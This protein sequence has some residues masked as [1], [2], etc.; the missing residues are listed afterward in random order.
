MNI[1]I[2][3]D[4]SYENDKLKNILNEYAAINKI[5]LKTDEYNNGESFLKNYSPYAYT[6]VFLDIF[7][8][9]L[10][11]V[12]IAKIIRKSDTDTI[13]VFLTSSVEHMADAFS[14]HAYDYIIKPTCKKKLFRVMDDILHN[15]TTFF[16]DKFSFTT[17]GQS[18][19]LAY[20][21]IVS[22]ITAEHTIV[23][24]PRIEIRPP[25]RGL[26]S[27]GRDRPGVCR[28]AFRIILCGG[29]GAGAGRFRGSFRRRLRR[30][31]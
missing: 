31:Q 17:E 18:Y 19:A 7:M 27:G 12:D 13:I 20:P 29:G 9:G 6:I 11:G 8:D 14:I 21:D 1:A 28:P 30:L 3:D 25:R 24:S 23:L 26:R 15:H 10:S 22:V 16:S 5:A 2:V 4:L